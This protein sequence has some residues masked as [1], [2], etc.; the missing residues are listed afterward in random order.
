[1]Y[2]LLNKFSLSTIKM[3]ILDIWIHVRFLFILISFWIFIVLSWTHF[4]KVVALIKVFMTFLK[5]N[6]T[7]V[8]FYFI[9]FDWY[10]IFKYM[11][12]P[13]AEVIR[14]HTTSMNLRIYSIVYCLPF[15]PVYRWASRN[16]DTDDIFDTNML[17]WNKEFNFTKY[18]MKQH[19][20]L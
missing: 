2:Y 3:A 15:L 12:S 9:H 7:V 13:N 19:V 1:M 8:C 20:A 6:S 4:T 17:D 5:T 11:V 14:I 18:H 16:T 10:Y